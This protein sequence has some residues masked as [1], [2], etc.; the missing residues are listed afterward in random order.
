MLQCEVGS[1]PSPATTT[2]L[3]VSLLEHEDLHKEAW[4]LARQ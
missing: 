3:L 2:S 4:Y 1:T